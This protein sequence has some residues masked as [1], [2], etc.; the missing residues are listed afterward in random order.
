MKEIVLNKPNEKLIRQAF[1][2]INTRKPYKK[3]LKKSN[4][5]TIQDIFKAF[6]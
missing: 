6:E 5:I 1:L 2:K 4:K 3:K